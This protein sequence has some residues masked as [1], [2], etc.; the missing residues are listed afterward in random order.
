MAGDIREIDMPKATDMNNKKIRLVG[1]DGQ[2]YWMEKEDLAKVV[3]GL[4]PEAN[5][6]KKGLM[7]PLQ[8]VNGQ[9]MELQL[10]KCAKFSKIVDAGTT[11]RCIDMPTGKIAYVMVADQ[12]TLKIILGEITNNN[13]HFYRDENFFYIQS[14]GGSLS[15]ISPTY[16]SLGTSIR[17]EE[18]S[19]TSSLEEIIPER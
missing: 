16:R 6:S 10:G 17:L 11:L 2:G 1:D 7:S 14:K 13:I 19:D 15:I 3:G 4:L 8:F 5:I 9:T 12:G 18:I